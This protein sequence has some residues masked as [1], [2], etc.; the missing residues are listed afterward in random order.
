MPALGQASDELRLVCWLKSEDQDVAEGEPL[1]EVDSDK[2][3]LDVEAVA[4]GTLL[5][6]LFEP[7]QTVRAGTVI[8][9]V[10]E[11][12]EV[13]PEAGAGDEAG[14]E[15][16]VPERQDGAVRSGG[17]SP[18]L[19]LAAA[20]GEGT[21]GTV[22]PAGLA[23]PAAAVERR[24]A[25]PAARLAGSGP[26]GRI[27]RGDVQK[28]IAGMQVQP[29]GIKAGG[30]ADEPVPAHRRLIAERLVRAA[31][32][33]Q[34]SLSRTV[35]AGRAL[36]RLAEV[37]G[38]TFTHLLLQAV[39]GALREH[40]RMDRV[41]VE[42]GPC[43]RRLEHA[44]VGLLIAIEDNLVTV[45]VPAPDRQSLGE[46]ARTTRTVVNQARSGRLRA[47]F[48]GPVAVTVSNLGMFAVDRFEAIVDPDQT[49]VLAVGQISQRAAVTDEGVKAVPQVDL[50]L[51]V[52]HRT[53]DGAEA[54]R[55]L[56]AVCAYLQR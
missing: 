2:T 33:P 22:N 38:A 46:L 44:D 56:A 7:G 25:T 19:A 29:G 6:L 47:S 31:L 14:A 34:F 27:E 54:A 18:V 15:G 13:L 4:T 36:Q 32:V 10:G 5:K 55:F 28:A 8:A 20:G 37:P 24:P 43:F 40:P 45:T 23:E 48:T 39:A 52:D 1:F 49:A 53:V 41:W 12:G 17:P 21:E 35:D 16:P 42:E 9:W 26:G 3:T 50:T 51:G 11:R 30:Q